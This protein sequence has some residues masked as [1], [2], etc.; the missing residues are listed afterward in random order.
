M[1]AECYSCDDV[2]RPE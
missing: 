1:F 2:V